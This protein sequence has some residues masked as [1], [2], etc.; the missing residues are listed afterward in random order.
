MVAAVVL[1]FFSFWQSRWRYLWFLH[2]LIFNPVIWNGIV[3]GVGIG[4]DVDEDNVEHLEPSF[5]DEDA[6]DGDQPGPD[7]NV[8]LPRRRNRGE[9]QEEGL[10]LIS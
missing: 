1:E 5:G 9:L 2:Y 8:C 3:T 6:Y 10:L 4:N 7:G